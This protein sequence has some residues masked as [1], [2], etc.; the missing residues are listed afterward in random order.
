MKTALQMLQA[1]NRNEIYAVEPDSTVF[2]ALQL[3]AEKNIGAVLVMDGS[4]LVGIFSERDYARKVVLQGKTSAGTLISDIMT[5]RVMYA[6]PLQTLEE[7]MS[8]MSEKRFRHLP[9]MDGDKLL[10]ILSITDLVR[11]QIAE[12]QFLI[13]QLEQYIMQ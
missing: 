10:G 5:K 11:E 3:M 13:Q 9:V 4:K 1:K 6:T 2:Q 7:C 12:Q 8:I